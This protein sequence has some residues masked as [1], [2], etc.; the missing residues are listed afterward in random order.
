LAAQLITTPPPIAQLRIEDFRPVLLEPASE[1]API[2]RVRPGDVVPV[3]QIDG[4]W[5]RGE[6]GWI[7]LDG[8]QPEAA[9]VDYGAAFEDDLLLAP[10]PDAT[11]TMTLS[12]DEP[13]GVA[14]I[15]YDWALVYGRDAA[16]W[17]A[18]DNLHLVEPLPDVADFVEREAYVMVEAA[19]LF[20]LPDADAPTASQEPLGRRVRVLFSDGGWALVKS[21]S[22][23]GWSPLKNFDFAPGVLAR[24]T[25]NAGPVNVRESPVDGAVLTIVEYLEVVRI[26]E[27][28][29][30][31]LYVRLSDARGG[32]KGWLAAQFV[33]FEIEEN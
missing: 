14:A 26:L 21:G 7:S 12:P 16:G 19:D 4:E 25:M 8:L 27:V 28:D 9:V 29:G 11:T 15:F 10:E 6:V 23:V 13:V 5:A 17:T 22:A 20:T 2:D 24:G 3:F 31:W 1:D 18:L 32:L 30:N 33:D